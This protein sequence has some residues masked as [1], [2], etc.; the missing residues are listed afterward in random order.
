[1]LYQLDLR[2]REI[3]ETPD[4]LFGGVAVFMFGDILQLRP[5]MAKW[6][7]Q[8]PENEAFHLTNTL[9]PIW[10]KAQVMMLVKNHRQEGD[11]E[12]ADL[13]AR[14]RVGQDNEKDIKMLNTRVRPNGHPDLPPNALR[15][16]SNNKDVNQ[17]NERKLAELKEEEHVF[18]AITVSRAQKEL[19]S[20]ADNTGA[21][22]GSQ[23]QKTLKLK[24]GA[25]VVMTTNV[26]TTDCLTNGTFGT[27]FGFE[28]DE[29]GKI[30]SVLVEFEKE[31]SGKELRKKRPD[32]ERKFPGRNI[33]VIKKVEQEYSLSGKSKGSAT[34]RAIQ[35]PLKLVFATTAHKVQVN[36]Y[37]FKII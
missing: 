1:M 18:E 33:T 14:V 22:K 12:Y 37:F 19:K 10:Q 31:K 17:Y 7:F 21:I 4:I 16:M 30:N 5:V 15:V 3:K 13:L 6:I 29:N 27:V 8:E 20:F 11:K 36:F 9:D 24:I 26:D 32:I 35:Y 23:L 34:A 2:L 25:K 28:K